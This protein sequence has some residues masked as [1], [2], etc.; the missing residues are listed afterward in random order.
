MVWSEIVF[1][2]Q[3]VIIIAVNKVHRPYP[4]NTKF[5][6]ALAM[7]LKDIRERI[8]GNCQDA[9]LIKEWERMKISHGMMGSST[10]CLP[11]FQ[12]P[13]PLPNY[14]VTAYIG[15]LYVKVVPMS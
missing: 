11:Q 7:I 14:T 12:V 9:S 8:P 6:S 13:L 2:G 15:P 10:Y 5:N 3:V 4:R 1:R